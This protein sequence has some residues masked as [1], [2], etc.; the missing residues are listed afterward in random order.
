MPTIGYC[1]GCCG[2]WTD[3]TTEQLLAKLRD[4]LPDLVLRTTLI[5]GFPGE[6]AAEFEELVEF[7]Q[8]QRFER[9]GVFAYSQ[10]PETPA[11]SL[12]D[13]VSEATRAAAARS[14]DDRATR[15]CIS[16]ERSPGRKETATS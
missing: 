3:Q 10:E 2:G 4:R 13:Q 15:D 16:M 5:T 14:A 1:G 9:L 6:T 8:Q 7:V 12:A 11:A